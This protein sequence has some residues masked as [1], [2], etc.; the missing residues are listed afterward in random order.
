MAAW[1]LTIDLRGP[2]HA[3][4]DLTDEIRD[5][6]VRIIQD[7]EWENPSLDWMLV[8]LSQVTDAWEFDKVFAWIYDLAN[9][10]NVCLDT[11]EP[12]YN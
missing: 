4:P 10:D 6:I 2:W 12:Q 11:R 3:D 8:S 9:A 1:R 7:S 5:E